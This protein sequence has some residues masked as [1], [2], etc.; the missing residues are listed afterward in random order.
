MGGAGASPEPTVWIGTDYN[1]SR[2]LSIYLDSAG[3][4]DTICT[5]QT[6]TI[7]VGSALD[8]VLVN[9]YPATYITSYVMISEDGITWTTIA[10]GSY[11]AGTYVFPS[12]YYG[13]KLY[14]KINMAHG[15]LSERRGITI[16]TMRLRS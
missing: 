16:N 12:N 4:I 14:I 6:P 5:V 9:D 1:W 15:N 8:Y 10:Q 13:K 7:K 2:G 11:V 3:Q